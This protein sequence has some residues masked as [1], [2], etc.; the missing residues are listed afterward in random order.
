LCEMWNTHRRGFRNKVL[1]RRR[2]YR[3]SGFEAA[4]VVFF[5]AIV[6]DI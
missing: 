4:F 3:G 2:F 5:L 1:D 6:G